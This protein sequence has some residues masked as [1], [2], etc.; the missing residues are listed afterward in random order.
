[1]EQVGS[2][3]RLDFVVPDTFAGVRVDTLLRKHLLLSGAVIRRI[4]W[5]EDG[6]LVDGERV[7]TRFIPKPGQVLSVRLSDPERLSGILP[8]SGRLDIVCEDEDVIVLNKAPGVSVHPGPGHYDDTLGNFLVD[9]YIK[10]GQSADFHPVH[11]LDRGTSGLLVVAKHPHAQERLK[12]QLHSPDFR[13]VYL[14]VCEGEPQ[15]PCGMIDAP[16]GPVEGS[17]M[18]QQVRPDGKPARTRYETV[19]TAGERTLLRLE[20]ET[21]RTHQI[22]VHMAHIGH[23]LTG[24]FL[25]GTEDRALISHTALHSHALSFLHPVTGAQMEFSQPLPPDMEQLV[26]QGAHG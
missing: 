22:R 11:R 25:Y 26:P 2:V 6:I 23:P 15:P 12:E 24:D 16:L 1:M 7:N 10:T 4:K 3:R 8:T 9:Y 17:L 18:A 5:L 21:G 13:R 14:A 19:R 20:L